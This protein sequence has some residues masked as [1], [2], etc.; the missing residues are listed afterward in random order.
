MAAMSFMRRAWDRWQII[1]KANGDFIAR[2][3]IALF[4]CT[5]CAAFAGS[6]RLI[7]R[8]H[9]TSDPLGQDVSTDWIIRRADLPS[10]PDA[11][12]QF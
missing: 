3:A 11:R 4:Y 5:I 9:P 7:H 12:R 2:V 6:A 1:N 8:L 10:L